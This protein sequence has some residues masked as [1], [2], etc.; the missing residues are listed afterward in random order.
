M[1]AFK[2]IIFIDGICNLCNNLVRFVYKFDKNE[3]FAY[4]SIQGDYIKTISS[5]YEN[6]IK[7][8]T[9]II[10][11]TIDNKFYYRSEAIKYI[12]LNLNI[13]LK[14]FGLLFYLIPI[15][16]RD[17]IYNLVAKYRYKIFGIT[18]FC[19]FKNNIK[20]ERFIL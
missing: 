17:W 5:K 14:V 3:T 4:S 9:V 15:K 1:T 2:Y 19:S 6:L 12:L 20:D 13:S 16:L 7:N 11:S 18:E 10:Y 8:D